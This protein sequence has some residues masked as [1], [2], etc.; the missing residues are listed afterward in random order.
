MRGTAAASTRKAVQLLCQRPYAPAPVSADW[1]AHLSTTL[2]HHVRRA[3]AADS[4]TEQ[5]AA[6]IARLQD[7]L[8][9][10]DEAETMAAADAQPNIVDD[11]RQQLERR[12]HE[13]ATARMMT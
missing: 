10:V 13:V 4:R 1:R 12:T 7:A 2:V 6:E 9:A 5:L 8:T 3:E 11:L